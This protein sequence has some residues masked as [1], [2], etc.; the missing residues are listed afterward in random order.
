MLISV[1]NR[2]KSISDETLQCAIR[3]I[4][5]Q[6]AEDFEPY[7]SFGA[8]L[9]L[10]GAIGATPNK[11]KLEEMRGDAVL[12]LWD[13]TDVEDALGYHE[14]NFCGIPYGFIFT[15]LCK[16]LKEEW[17][18]TLSHEALELLGD[19]QGNLLVQGPHP[20]DP[21][22]EV[23]HWFEMCD[24]VQSEGYAI[25][26][27]K[28]SNFVL[29]LY[30]TP[31]E[32][33]GGRNDFLGRLYKGK[34]LHS[35]GVNPG[36]Y[37]GYY[38]PVSKQHETY[39]AKNDKAAQARLKLKRASK[40][41]RGYLRQ[42]GA[43]T[44]QKEVAHQQA[45]G[46]GVASAVA[47]QT[48]TDPIRHVVVLM[49][50]NR[51]FD[52]LLGDMSKVNSDIDGLPQGGAAR[53]NTAT[54]TGHVYTQ[55][56]IAKSRLTV[57]LDHEHDSV[58]QQLGST[59]QAMSGFVDSFLQH[60]PQAKDPDDIDQ[61]MAYFP[62]GDTPAEDS[63]PVLHGL[64]R[65]FLVC[66]KWFSSMPG[67]T[68]P[69][70]FFVHSGTCLGHV[71]MPSREH[72][73]Y[74]RVYSQ[75]TLYDRLGD[76]GKPWKIYHDG[77]PQSIVLTRLLPRFITSSY[78][79]MDEFEQDAKGAANDFPAYAFI[80]P[81]YFGVN[82]NDQHP[83]SDI[84]GGEQ[85]IAR[86]YNALR[87]N[88]ELW[89]STLLIV[90]YDEH[91]GFYDHVSPPDTIAP[92]DQTSE[93]DFRRLGVRVPALLVSPWVDPGVCHTVFDHTSILRY[94]C[95]KFGM[96]PLGSRTAPEAGDFRANTFAMELTKRSTPRTN[97]PA[98]LQAATPPRGARVAKTPA[99][100]EGSREALMLYLAGLAEPGPA[101]KGMR[102]RATVRG[103]KKRVG[104]TE[105]QAQADAAYAQLLKKKALHK[106]ATSKH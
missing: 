50:E 22:R 27:V 13:Q 34:P 61:V 55:Q 87:G 89:Q 68:W 84:G 21:Q 95:D 103:K 46:E 99:P 9:R 43:G 105:L 47:A 25:D 15:D 80:E 12:Y 2:A 73:E 19:A 58:M 67:P 17:S 85:L 40:F 106:R 38:D 6:I 66:D 102:A 98:Q 10:E 92:D 79:S 82:E 33:A 60:A 78:G 42:H 88:A 97:T 77:M 41:G 28:L 75:E 35:F 8:K 4:N 32:Q 96:P 7:W 81:A 24:A 62:V 65:Q 53:S 63:L 14:A 31:E 64:A 39:F 18:V 69:N 56:G 100:V 93:Y 36:G 94:M 45:L 1:V 90:V 44:I 20:T 74:M 72:P 52:H 101:P 23:F 51:S 48:N 49:M 5:R 11:Q 83:P 57:D 37:I 54:G 59:A 16:K 70:R 26:G 29:P 91:G 3:A 76:Q 71:L 30:F 104:D 86:V